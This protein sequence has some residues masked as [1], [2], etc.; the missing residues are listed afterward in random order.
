VFIPFPLLASPLMPHARQDKQ[1]ALEKELA[2]ARGR[3]AGYEQRER[4]EEE[5][6]RLA[7]SIWGARRQPDATWDPPPVLLSGKKV[8]PLTVGR[9]VS[10]LGYRCTSQRVHRISA[11]VQQAYVCAH[12][13]VPVPVIYYDREGVP[14]RVTSYTESDRGLIEAVIRA[15][16]KP[17][18][19][20]GDG[21]DDG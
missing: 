14:E 9:V 13:R 18:S 10:D 1:A 11:L 7:L 5:Q 15:H 3:L 20:P 6:H 2:E 17:A 8:E 21:S 12:G 16:C 19:P 4:E